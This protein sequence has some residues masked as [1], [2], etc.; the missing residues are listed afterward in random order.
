MTHNMLIL[1]RFICTRSPFHLLKNNQLNYIIKHLKTILRTVL[2]TLNIS[3]LRNI[4]EINL[5]L[6]FLKKKKVH[7]QAK[8]KH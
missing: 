6:K 5:T 1:V 3:H 8:S 7:L 4:L 2:E